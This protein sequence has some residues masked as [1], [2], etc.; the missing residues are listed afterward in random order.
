MSMHSEQNFQKTRIKNDWPP[1]HNYK[2]AIKNYIILLTKTTDAQ[3]E[4]APSYHIVRGL[5]FVAVV[6]VA[7]IVNLLKCNKSLFCGSLTFKRA[8]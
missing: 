7:A 8:V 5:Y 1:Q 2:S 3:N 6:F 4:V